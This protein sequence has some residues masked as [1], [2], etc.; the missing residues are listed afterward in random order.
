[1]GDFGLSPTL[2]YFEY[3]FDS[4]DA[5]LGYSASESK[6]D[7]PNFQM[8]RPINNI[9]G[10]KVLEVQIPF[11]F[12]VINQ[13]NNTFV[14]VTNNGNFTITIP[15]GNYDSASLIV[16]TTLALQSADP[17][18][19]WVITYSDITGKF[20][21]Y[22]AILFSLVFGAANSAG[23]DNPAF[24]YGF[25]TGASD[26]GLVLRAPRVAD[27]T[28]PLY[29]YLCSDVLGTLCALHL[30]ASAELSQGGLGPEIAKIP[31][32]AN[33]W[34]IINWIDPDPQK[35]FDV[36]SLFTLQSVDFYLTLGKNPRKPLKLN[37]LP[38]SIKLGIV[39][40]N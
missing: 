7:W 30:P 15:E 23:D 20:T 21:F 12:Y 13:F 39:I 18:G 37:G 28:G 10:L 27:I 22:S 4:Q 29:V 40:S 19:S 38:F 31:V 14:L 8:E 9:A 11:S 16:A 17:M 26:T 1:M 3:E 6:L 36:E 5:V 25:N 32:N 24:I 34:N 33:P 2:R 35:F